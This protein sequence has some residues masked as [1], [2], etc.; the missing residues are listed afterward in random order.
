MESKE[1]QLVEFKEGIFVIDFDETKTVSIKKLKDILIEYEK[2]G[3]TYI[4][5]EF[6]IWD[7]EIE[8]LWFSF[9][10]ERLETDEEFDD[11]INREKKLLELTNRR[12]EVEEQKERELYLK[13]KEKYGK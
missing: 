12:K 4:D 11:R 2:I 13:L 10:K 7:N 5:F 1:K 3:C 9:I 8:K 6:N